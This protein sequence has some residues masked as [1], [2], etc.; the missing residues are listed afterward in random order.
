MGKSLEGSRKATEQWAVGQEGGRL[1]G[2]PEAHSQGQRVSMEGWRGRLASCF[3]YLGVF[4]EKNRLE[5]I[6]LEFKWGDRRC[7]CPVSF[8]LSTHTLTCPCLN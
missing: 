7:S 6:P 3:P 1:L 5:K 8:P 4:Q 2:W